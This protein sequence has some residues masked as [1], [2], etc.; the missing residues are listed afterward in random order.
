M[1]RTLLVAGG[2]EAAGRRFE[3]VMAHLA[4][5]EGRDQPVGGDLNYGRPRRREERNLKIA[6][7]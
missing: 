4:P 6:S 5:P 7:L 1:I 2:G 3:P